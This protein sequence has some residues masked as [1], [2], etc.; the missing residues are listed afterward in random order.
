MLYA[1]VGLGRRCGSLF[2]LVWAMKGNVAVFS[3][4]C[5]CWREM[6]HDHEGV[7][8]AADSERRP[9]G[10]QSGFNH[11]FGGS[12]CSLPSGV[13]LRKESVREMWVVP[14]NLILPRL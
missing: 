13:L 14:P 12:A 8:S 1:C 9:P 3:D 4:L 7:T 10:T 6:F 2:M 11:Q 5:G